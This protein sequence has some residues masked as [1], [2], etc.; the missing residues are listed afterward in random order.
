MGSAFRTAFVVAVAFAESG[1]GLGVSQLPEVWDR[2]DGYATARIGDADK[3]G[4]LC[5]LRKGAC[6]PEKPIRANITIRAK[7]YRGPP[8][9]PF[10]N[11][12]GAQVTLDPHREREVGLNSEHDAED[13]RSPR[14]PSIS[15]PLRRALCFALPGRYRHKTSAMTNSTSTTRLRT[16][17]MEPGRTTSAMRLRKSFWGQQV[18]VR[19]LSTL[20][21]SGSKNGCPARSRSPISSAP[22]NRRSRG[23]TA[24]RNGRQFRSDSATYDDKF[25]WCAR[26]K[27]RGHLEPRK[28]CYK[29]FAAVRPGIA[30]VP[31]NCSSLSG[32]VPRRRR[33]TKRP[34]RSS[35]SMS[36]RS[37]RAPSTRTSP[38]KSAVPSR[39]LVIGS[40]DQ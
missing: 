18:R 7:S 17:F 11:S 5:E 21:T 2:T 33:K 32:P 14:K 8:T 31:T 29:R 10:P 39:P 12:W 25:V 9:A 36:G 37:F 38:R 16:S 22:R 13:P 24:Y 35:L 6:S 34:A 1:C 27:H 15:R 3:A 30:P 4:D 26:R 20:A 19:R 23:R 40:D 28:S